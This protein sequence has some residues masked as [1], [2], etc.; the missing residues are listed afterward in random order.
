MTLDEAIKEITFFL[1]DIELAPNTK[2]GQALKMAIKALG[3]KLLV[4]EYNG[5]EHKIECES[6][7]FRTNQVANWI[8]I[9]H[10]DGSTEIIRDICV[11]KTESED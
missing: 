8:R 7:E 3:Q 1:N 5:T 6:F 10:S 9:N 2:L 4:I 11:I